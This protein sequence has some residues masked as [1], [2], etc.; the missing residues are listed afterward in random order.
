MVA[1]CVL[2]AAPIEDAQAREAP[3][4]VVQKP[5]VS[6]ARA[7]TTHRG[8]GAFAHQTGVASYYGKAHNGKRTASGVRFNQEA[9]TAA[10]SSLPFGTKVKVT[11]AATG[12]S[13]VV[14]INDRLYSGRRIIDLSM[15]AARQLGMIRQGIATVSITPA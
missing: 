11:H 6:K 5:A 9:L 15:S 10:H 13:V 2:I 3:A 8:A 1:A 14:V 7:A 12:R 4:R